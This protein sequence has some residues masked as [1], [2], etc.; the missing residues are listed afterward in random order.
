MEERIRRHR[1]SRPVGWR[2]LE[3]P[4]HLPLAIAEALTPNPSP[5]SGRG[6]GGEGCNA[7]VLV[8]CLNLWVSNLLLQGQG[9]E[10]AS[11]EAEVLDSAKSLLDCYERGR[12]TFILVSNEVGLGLV[13][14]HPLGRQF[15]DMLGKVNQMVAARADKVYLLVAG[16]PLELKSL[17]S[18][19][20]LPWEG[21]R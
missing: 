2:S 19:H 8:D 13:P 12:A 21:P 4:I 9:K 20:L 6:A 10:P 5:T 1:A 3:E 16:L 14:A 11:I 17:S 7:V 15:R 18:Q